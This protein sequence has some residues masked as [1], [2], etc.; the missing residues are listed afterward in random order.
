MVL[1]IHSSL[2]LPKGA[3][4]DISPSNHPAPWKFNMFVISAYLCF[5]NK[6]WGSSTLPRTNF[7]PFSERYLRNAQSPWML[8]KNITQTFPMILKPRRFDFT[9]ACLSNITWWRRPRYSCGERKMR[10]WRL[11]WPK[12][13][14]FMLKTISDSPFCQKVATG[15]S[16]TNL[17]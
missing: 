3:S 13:Q 15:F 16:R 7:H 1:Y 9:A 17:T 12:S 6:M 14:R 8:W 10:L 4:K 5:M 2:S 11:R